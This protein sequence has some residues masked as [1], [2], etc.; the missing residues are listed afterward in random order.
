M[1]KE[2]RKALLSYFFKAIMD[3]IY[4]KISGKKKR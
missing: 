2:R 1:L 3:D 4:R